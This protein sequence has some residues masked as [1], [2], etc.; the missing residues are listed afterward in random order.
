MKALKHFHHQNVDDQ[1]EHWRETVETGITVV[2]PKIV[3]MM[4]R[5][6]DAE[7]ALNLH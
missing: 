4:Q 6:H 5:S 1:I 2:S 3:H 7:V